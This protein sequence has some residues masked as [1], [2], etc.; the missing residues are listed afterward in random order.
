MFKV[1]GGEEGLL[2]RRDRSGSQKL[3]SEPLPS[4]A[5]AANARSHLSHRGRRTCR[6][7]HGPQPRGSRPSRSVREVHSEYFVKTN[8]KERIRVL[9]SQS[10]YLFAVAQMGVETDRGSE[11]GE[12]GPPTWPPPN[13]ATRYW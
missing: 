8:N 7:I 6:V 11:V 5:F 10:S 3:T 2:S 12:D 13:P 4:L 1:M 9:R